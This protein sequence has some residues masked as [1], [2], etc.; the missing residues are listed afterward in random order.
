MVNTAGA[1]NPEEVASSVSEVFNDEGTISNY[2]RT[3]GSVAGT[4]RANR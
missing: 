3:S 1:V 2:Y 4:R